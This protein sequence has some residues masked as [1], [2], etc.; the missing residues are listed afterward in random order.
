MYKYYIIS[1]LQQ[2]E[3]NKAFNIFSNVFSYNMKI[4]LWLENIIFITFFLFYNS[5]H[6]KK[7]ATKG[8]KLT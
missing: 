1:N 4:Y 5:K 3:L 8:Q 7:V 6:G 2:F